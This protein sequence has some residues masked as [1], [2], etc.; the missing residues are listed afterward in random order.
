MDID[1]HIIRGLPVAIVDNFYT[2]EEVDAIWNEICFLNPNLLRPEQTGGAFDEQS[3]DMM[4]QNAATFVDQVFAQPFF[5]NILQT[6][7]KLFMRETLDQFIE[8]H[9]FFRYIDQTNFDTTL[10]SRYTTN[11]HYKPHIDASTVS[12]LTWFCREPKKF[13]GGELVIDD[14]EIETKNNRLVLMPGILEHGVKPVTL[15]SDDTLDG[16][17]TMTQ[18]TMLR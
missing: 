15:N 14:L 3:G 4:K 11:D 12:A 1:L 10:I 7:R 13:D 17:F 18:F 2:E 9:Y 16:R 5:S 6:N 8:A